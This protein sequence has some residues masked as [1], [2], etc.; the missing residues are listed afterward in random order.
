MEAVLGALFIFLLR[1]G[2][3]S[4]G[5]LRVVL[6]VSGRKQPATMLAFCESAIW[7]FAISRVFAKIDGHPEKMI[8]YAAGYAAGTLV[9]MTVEQYLAFGEQLVRVITRRTDANM[10][11][12]LAAEGFGVTSF[13]GQGVGGPVEELMIA[14]PRK[15][16]TKLLKLVR[17]IDPKAFITVETV[18]QILGGFI[19][20]AWTDHGK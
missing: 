20:R 13:C 10:K 18:T 14:I 17:D 4:V 16:R 5:T 19:P 6:L 3:V 11:E 12:L 9:G 7:I 1:I 8:A 15:R 2:D